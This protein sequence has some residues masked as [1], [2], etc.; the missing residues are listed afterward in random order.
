MLGSDIKNS[1]LMELQSGVI[2]I[3]WTSKYTLLKVESKKSISIF[4]FVFG[5]IPNFDFNLFYPIFILIKATKLLLESYCRDRF[6]YTLQ[7]RVVI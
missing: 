3:L 7:M 5:T 4:T 2:P 1:T 6:T